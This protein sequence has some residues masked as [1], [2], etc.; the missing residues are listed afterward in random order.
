MTALFF[1]SDR[2]I[3]KPPRYC[4]APCGCFF[5]ASAAFSF[6]AFLSR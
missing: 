3:G 4:A 2:Q 6:C 5:F 1:C